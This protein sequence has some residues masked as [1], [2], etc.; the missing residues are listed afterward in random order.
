MPPVSPVTFPFS[1]G[2]SFSLSEAAPDHMVWRTIPFSP[3]SQHEPKTLSTLTVFPC[4]FPKYG[5]SRCLWST[6]SLRGKEEIFPS[7]PRAFPKGRP[8]RWAFLSLR[9]SPFCYLLSSLPA[10]PT[11]ILHSFLCPVIHSIYR[12]QTDKPR[13]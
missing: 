7:L 1:L 12:T 6:W 8:I 10:G 11:S 13:V 4:F 3:P 5:L 9:V 2:F